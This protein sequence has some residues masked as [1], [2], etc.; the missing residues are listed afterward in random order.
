MDNVSIKEQIQKQVKKQFDKQKNEMLEN[1]INNLV[2]KPTNVQTDVPTNIPLH[3]HGHTH[4]IVTRDPIRDYDYRKLHDPLEEPTRRVERYEIP[5]GYVL[6]H[7]DLPTRGYPDNFKQVG[8]LICVTGNKNARHRSG[9]RN[10]H[11]DRWDKNGK[12]QKEEKEEK[13]DNNVN[14]ENQL[15]KLFGRQEYPG[16]NRWDYFT[17]ARSGLESI[18][19][20]VD[21]RNNR[22]LY[23]GDIVYVSELDKEYRVQL[24][25][26]DAP[27]YLP[28]IF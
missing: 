6:K 11:R 26:F 28:H 23:D 24:H 12:D 9:R 8:L 10:R 16:S 17:S 5:P 25:D 18:K 27:K 19:L 22:E 1:E 3:S 20:Q 13:A 4:N 15:L 21:N 2:D 7:I 14:N